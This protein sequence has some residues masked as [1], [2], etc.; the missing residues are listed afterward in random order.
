MSIIKIE[1]LPSA[2]ADLSRLYE[3]INPHN[4]AVATRAVQTIILRVD[5]LKA[6]PEMGKVCS[7]NQEFRELFIPFGRN[8]YVLRYRNDRDKI[9]IAR[10]WHGKESREQ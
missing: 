7:V 8:Q 5:Q 1:W 10:I 4:P 2:L 6:Q 3:F 9:I